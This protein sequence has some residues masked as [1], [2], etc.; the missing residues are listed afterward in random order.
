MATF[1]DIVLADGSATPVNHTFKTKTSSGRV[2]IWEDRVSGIPVSY[3]KLSVETKDND[4]VRRVK[5]SVAI[6][7]LEAAAGANKDG[8]TPAATVAYIHRVNVE[9][10]L[11]QRGIVQNRKDILA[12]LKNA[13][14]NTVLAAII[15]DGDEI[16]G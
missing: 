15:T 14:S 12:Y 11:P 1:A 5:L 6:P 8:F 2:A 9:F 3:G 13:L 7:T 4:T 10:L 16:A